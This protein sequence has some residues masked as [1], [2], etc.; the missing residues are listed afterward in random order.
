MEWWNYLIVIAGAVLGYIV[1][2]LLEKYANVWAQ[3]GLEFLDVV[4]IQSVLTV[5]QIYVDER[6]KGLEDG[7]WT[8]EERLNAKKM[9]FDW[10]WAQVPKKVMDLLVKWFG[11]KGKLE[12]Y[13]SAGIEAAVKSSKE[14][15]L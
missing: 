14:G 12:A 8:D 1:K 7:T 5:N 6:K 13:V 9:C 3:R 11:D 2:W 10:I 15:N 4:I